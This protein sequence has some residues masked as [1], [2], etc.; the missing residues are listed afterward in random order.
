MWTRAD[1]HAKLQASVVQLD[2]CQTDQEVAGLTFFVEINHEIFSKVLSL[3]LI[4][5]GHLSS[6]LEKNVQNTG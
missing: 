3:L 5:K 2:A 1:Y 4:Q 6:F